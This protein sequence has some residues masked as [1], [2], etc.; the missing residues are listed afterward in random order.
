[1]YFYWNSNNNLFIIII[2]LLCKL[3]I[4]GKIYQKLEIR[5]SEEG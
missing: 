1:M 3:R 4:L 2:N 5:F